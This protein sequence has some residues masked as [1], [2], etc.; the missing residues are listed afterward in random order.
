MVVV[1]R[2]SQIYSRR[3]KP[4]RLPTGKT[5]FHEVVAPK[6]ERVPLGPKAVGYTERSLNKLIEDGVN[7]A[8]R[9]RRARQ[10]ANADSAPAQTNTIR[11][12][13]L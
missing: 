3:G 10:A 4:G 2:A 7:A 12:G 9:D 13:D 5:H 8:E 11:T 6:L 1:L